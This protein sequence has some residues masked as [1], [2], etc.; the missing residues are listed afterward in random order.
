VGNVLFKLGDV[1]ATV[2][3]PEFSPWN[4]PGTTLDRLEVCEGIR[5]GNRN[6]EMSSH[7][8][9]LNDIEIE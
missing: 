4:H 8:S 2:K 3:D 9:Y 1:E 6:E 7:R 5:P